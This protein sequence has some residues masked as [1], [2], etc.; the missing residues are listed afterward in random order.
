MIMTLGGGSLKEVSDAHGGNVAL[1]FAITG[2]G[3]DNRAGTLFVNISTPPGGMPAG[4]QSPC[5]DVS[6]FAGIRFWAKGPAYVTF[7]AYSPKA[8]GES[9][10]IIAHL[11]ETHFGVNNQWQPIEIRW[12]EL[13]P[14][15]AAGE[16]PFDPAA[17]WFF[18]FA[19]SG[20]SDITFLLD[21][22]A[23]IDGP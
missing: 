7:T 18:T 21:D 6:R 1:A 11:S 13:T 17:L 23:F 20:Q 8:T 2:S 15:P 3:V 10:S 9:A 12:D 22:L 4:A 19:P 14:A 5:I 16:D